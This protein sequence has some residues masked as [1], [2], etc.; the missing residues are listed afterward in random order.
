M[1]RSPTNK[2]HI[3]AE[4]YI[5][6][7]LIAVSGLKRLLPHDETLAIPLQASLG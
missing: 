5:V 1:K 4:A 2:C 6:L 7:E 3:Q